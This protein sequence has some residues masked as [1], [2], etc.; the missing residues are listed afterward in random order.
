MH[1]RYNLNSLGYPKKRVSTSGDTASETLFADNF[2]CLP[3]LSNIKIQAKKTSIKCFLLFS[4]PGSF[5]VFL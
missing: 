3:P 5:C 1:I 4:C 2:M